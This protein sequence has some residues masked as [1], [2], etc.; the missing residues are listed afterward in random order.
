MR[1]MRSLGLL[2]WACAAALLACIVCWIV[3]VAFWFVGLDQATEYRGEGSPTTESW[4][5]ASSLGAFASG[6][7]ALVLLIVLTAL[8]RSHPWNAADSAD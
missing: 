7:T 5:R 2:R 4:L 3:Y 1:P 8:R 6:A